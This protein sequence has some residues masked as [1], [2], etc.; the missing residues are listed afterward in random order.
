MKKLLL[1]LPLCLSIQACSMVP[2]EGLDLVSTPEKVA[3]TVIGA[4]LGGYIGGE[5]GDGVA[6]SAGETI[7]LIGGTY[8]GMLAPAMI[9]KN[10]GTPSGTTS[11]GTLPGSQ[12]RTTGTRTMPGSQIF[13]QNKNTGTATTAPGSQMFSQSKTTVRRGNY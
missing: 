13:S 9:W 10:Y 1:L 12:N 8:L 2:T 7:G 5:L 6:D 3:S 4:V 11:S